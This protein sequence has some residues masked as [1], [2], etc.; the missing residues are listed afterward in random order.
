MVSVRILTPFNTVHFNG[1]VRRRV[2]I[3]GLK[4]IQD[5]Y[6]DIQSLRFCLQWFVEDYTYISSL[7]KCTITCGYYIAI[8]S[9]GS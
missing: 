6:F 1:L 9:V 4:F 3:Q 5:K 8:K 2:L 7:K